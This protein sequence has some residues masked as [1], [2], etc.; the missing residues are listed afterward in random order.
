M[1]TSEASRMAAPWLAAQHAERPQHR[2]VPGSDRFTCPRNHSHRL[3]RR[4]VPRSRVE[5]SVPHRKAVVETHDVLTE[6]FLHRILAIFYR[7]RV[8]SPTTLPI[9]PALVDD[10]DERV[11]SAEQ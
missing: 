1:F 6:R 11:L 3:D 8:Y 10:R 2:T 5:P 9:R 4:V 7:H